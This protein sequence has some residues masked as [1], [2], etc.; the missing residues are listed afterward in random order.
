MGEH[1]HPPSR[2][3]DDL[4][5]PILFLVRLLKIH[6]TKLSNLS[7]GWFPILFFTTVW[8]SEIYKSSVPDAVASDA[9]RSGSRALF[10]QSLV[11][12]ATSICLPF[13]ISES[14]VQPV[15]QH[16]YTSLNGNGVNPRDTAVWERAKEETQDGNP[17]K[18]AVGWAKGVMD[19]SAG[20]L[21][22]KGIRLVN[23]WWVSQFIFAGLMAASW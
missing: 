22:I 19:G 5:R 15:E 16:T 14:G 20:R 17:V 2:H 11:N 3:S 9:V 8:V 1:V 6:P 4:H 10:F 13:F 12:I 7:L 21:P 23:V 18:R